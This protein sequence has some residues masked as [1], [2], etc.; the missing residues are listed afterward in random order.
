MM[1]KFKP[2]DWVETGDPNL[3]WN[4]GRKEMSEWLL[5]LRYFSEDATVT[6][7]LTHNTAF[8][9]EKL[10]FGHGVSSSFPRWMEQIQFGQLA[11]LKV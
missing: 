10:W 2:E 11:G 7:G 8:P 9:W 3:G 4:V 1:S 6:D 5:E